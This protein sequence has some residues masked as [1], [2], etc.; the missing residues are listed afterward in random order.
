MTNRRTFFEFRKSRAPQVLGSCANN[1]VALASYVNE[2]TE[3]LVKAAGETGWFGTWQKVVFNVSTSDPYITLPRSI[4]RIVDLDVCKQP[5][6]IHNEF[7]EFLEA[8]I[9]LQPTNSCNCS[10][11]CNILSTYERGS[12]PTLKDLDSTGN[13]KVL[14]VYPTSIRDVGGTRILLQGLDQNGN[15]IRSLDNGIDIEGEYVVLLSPFA[16]TVNRFSTITGVQKDITSNDVLLYQVDT[17]T[18]TQV[19]LSRYEA[20]ETNPSYRRYFIN[21]LSTI[22]CCDGLPTAQVTA[23]AKLDFVPVAIDQDWLLI[24]NIPALKLECEA[25]RYAEFDNPQSQAMAER[26]H[27]QAIKLLN[28]ELNHYMGR[29]SPIVNFAPFG[30][31]KLI[32]ANVGTLI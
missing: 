28:E 18:G 15:V 20:S 11:P 31:A 7:Y 16:D 4:A 1:A 6:T 26:K 14:R 19:L 17:V 5:V 8:G 21:G 27:K 29:T 24:G 10:T 12:F 25:V 13:P 30:T 9:G 2:A 22:N 3:R 32:N 23:M